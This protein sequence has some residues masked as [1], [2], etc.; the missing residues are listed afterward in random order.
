[1]NKIT[2]CV[3]KQLNEKFSHSSNAKAVNNPQKVISNNF[4][5]KARDVKDMM[6][7]NNLID[8]EGLLK[9]LVELYPESTEL[10]IKI[11]NKMQFVVKNLKEEQVEEIL[12]LQ[13]KFNTIDT[14]FNETEQRLTQTH[15][16]NSLVNRQVTSAPQAIPSPNKQNRKL[17][18]LPN[19]EHINATE[20]SNSVL[21][22][23]QFSYNDSLLAP[24][25][26]NEN[27]YK[28]NSK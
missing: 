15:I 22:S 26:E 20:L 25:N 12:Q 8:I 24:N 18:T 13:S 2:S 14:S 10:V 11:H 9:Q 19:Y 16:S 27:N 28:I 1:M 4:K 7:N 5:A 21:E 23:I 3:N 17:H 6:I